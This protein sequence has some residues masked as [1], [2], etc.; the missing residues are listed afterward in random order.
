MLAF[1]RR[2]ARYAWTVA[3]VV[4]LLVL[5]YQVRQTLFV[6]TLAVLFAYLLAP[7]VDIF[8]R[9]LPTSRTRT[10]ALALAY[11]M[12]VAVLVITIIQIGTRV[13]EEANT[14]IKVFPDLLAKWQAPSPGAPDAVNSIKEQ[15]LSKIRE[16]IT[17]GTSSILAALPKAGLKVLSVATHLIDVIIVPIL[18]FFFLKDG[19][20]IRDGAVELIADGPKR[21][22]L[23]DLLADVNLL[24]AQYMRA[25]LTL[26]SAT[27]I[28]Y[29]IVFSIIGVPYSILLA[30]LAFALEFIP[31]IGPLTASVL[32]ILVAALS[33]GPVLGVL[34]FLAAYRLFQD[35]ILSPHVMGTG[36]ELHPLAIL[37]GVFA[38]AEVAGIP[39]AF[40]SVP[41]LALVRVFY[42]RLRKARVRTQLDTAPTVTL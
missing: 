42:V 6:F 32:I 2:A 33:G 21:H 10:P 11:V 28:T 15:I 29:S 19:R 23:E 26:C 5:V 24:L 9:L 3:L 36:L 39:G 35:Y 41:L 4:L 38:G 37:F 27:F 12:V 17:E 20:R 34:I 30:A 22:L 14:L 7:L 40:L 25:L 13:V 18:S 1:D 31:M 16:S 8:D